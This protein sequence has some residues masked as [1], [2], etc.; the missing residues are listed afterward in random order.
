MADSVGTIGLVLAWVFALV[1]AISLVLLGII[2]WRRR[3]LLKT[4][5]T[6]PA[7]ALT[8]VGGEK[9]A[10]ARGVVVSYHESSVEVLAVWSISPLPYFIFRWLATSWNYTVTPVTTAPVQMFAW[11]Y[12][13]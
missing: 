4:P 7:K 1:I 11:N 2:A 3:T 9:L 10:T 6:F 12:W 13:T 8:A 5:G